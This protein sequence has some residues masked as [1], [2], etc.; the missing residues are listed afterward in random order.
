[1]SHALLTFSVSRASLD[2]LH[3]EFAKVTY[4][5][6]SDSGDRLTRIL[7]A[8][9]SAEVLLTTASDLGSFPSDEGA[10][11]RVGK[12]LRVVQVGSAGVDAALGTGWVRGMVACGRIAKRGDDWRG[13]SFSDDGGELVF[14]TDS[15]RRG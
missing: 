14:L 8:L 4:L 10:L 12:G 3:S 6:P 7:H 2:L 9:E 11:G 1:M 5:P 15:F 13:G